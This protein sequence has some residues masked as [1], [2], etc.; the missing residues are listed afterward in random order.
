MN[1]LTFET[2]VADHHKIMGT[3]LRLTFAKV[4]PR[5]SILPLS[6]KL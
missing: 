4:K 3:M 6:Q 5:K 1:P 2:I